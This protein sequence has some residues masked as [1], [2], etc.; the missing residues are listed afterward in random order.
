MILQRDNRRISASDLMQHNLQKIA[1]T[2]QSPFEASSITNR[3]A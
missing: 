2:E 1:E 3:V